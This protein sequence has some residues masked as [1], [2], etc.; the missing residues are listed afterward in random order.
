MRN[1]KARIM[2][3]LTT[4]QAAALVPTLDGSAGVVAVY[5]NG[6]YV[7]PEMVVIPNSP[8]GVWGPDGP[9]NISPDA[10]GEE[11]TDDD[12]PEPEG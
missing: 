4:S 3:W 11:A 12:E 9:V 2:S 10:P 7:E 1:V 6:R 5:Q 8:E